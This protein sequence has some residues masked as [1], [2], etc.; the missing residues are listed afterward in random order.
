MTEVEV[1]DAMLRK[2]STP[3]AAIKKLQRGRSKDRSKGPSE[4]AVYAFWSGKSYARNN[5]ERRGRKSKVPPR[6]VRVANAERV[7]LLKSANNRYRVTWGDVHKATKK[8]LKER[9]DLTRR[10]RMPSLDWLRRRLREVQVRSRPGR[11]RI[12]RK[13]EHHSYDR[14]TQLNTNYSAPPK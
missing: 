2:K 10:H 8:A 7:K 14:E 12:S 1:L 3:Q 13:E 11:R 5:E 4:S 9:G 6:I